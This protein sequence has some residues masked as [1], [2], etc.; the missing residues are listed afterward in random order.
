MLM[1][2][3]AAALA[4]LGA[5][6]VAAATAP[7][8]RPAYAEGQVWEYRTRPQDA[9]SLV[10][11]QKVELWPKGE[12]AAPIYHVSV[13]GLRFDAPQ[14][15]AGAIEH[16]PVSRETLDASVTRLAA[17]QSASGFP[18]AEEGMAEWRAANGGVFTIT[19]AEI[20]QLLESTVA[21]SAPAERS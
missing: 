11:I 15:S 12:H 19:L 8:Q 5:D 18:S 7:A 6:P 9:G 10:R 17:D 13:V 16:L 1:T 4:A 20:V 3:F 14:L 21:G 2:L